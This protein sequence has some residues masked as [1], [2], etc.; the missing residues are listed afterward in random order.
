[1]ARTS[2]VHKKQPERA[3]VTK[4][5]I[6]KIYHVALY[7]R[8]SLLDSGHKDSD[9][10][11][12]QELLLRKFI[13]GKT[14]FSL[15]DV[16]VDNGESG[17]S[18]DRDSFK[19]MMEDVR[20]GRVDCI[21]VKDLSRFGRNYIEAGEY[22]EKVFPFLGVR[23]IAVND[24]I[25]TADPT[26]CDGL[27]LHLRN[28]VNDVYARD[29]SKKIS[30]VL[31]GKQQRGEFIGAWAAYGY[32]K[33][34]EDKH[35]L[36]IDEK[37]APVVRDIFA[38]RIEGFSYKD[39][40]RR[41]TAQGIPS[42]SK[43]RYMEGLVHDKRFSDVP[44]R[45]ETVKLI[46]GNEVYLGHTVQ[47]RKREC[48]FQGIKREWLPK[49]QWIIVKNT[50]KAIIDQPIFDKVQKINLIKKQKRKEMKE[51]FPEVGYTENILKG[52]VCCSICGE[53]LARRRNIWE[54]KYKTP[55]I[56]VWYKYICPAHAS[57]PARCS[58]Q[59]IKEQELLQAVFESIRMQV[60]L[61]GN[62]EKIVSLQKRNFAR[63]ERLQINSQLQKE[64]MELEK[65]KRHK[66]SLYDD[67]ADNLM[68]EQDY[69][70]AQARYREKETAL[71][72]H[73]LELNTSLELYNKEEP[74][75]NLWLKNTLRFRDVTELTREM[76]CALIE[77][78]TVYHDMAL[79]ITFR[80]QDDFKKLQERL[81]EG[82]WED[83]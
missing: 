12:T 44:W 17:V 72:R 48:L 70:Y 59:G 21:I 45:V 34:K 56:Q 23:F 10:A 64:R 8:L 80:F 67:Y 69:L 46:M 75:K 51:R 47:G 4:E 76:A 62:M 14:Y 1:M 43:Y 82:K 79:R 66:E 50:H 16:Y 68:N 20:A 36:V 41:L 65:I 73:I 77:K 71:Q 53:R 58:F 40:V 7:V 81:F 63:D 74:Q 61:A 11:E 83:E 28:L 37:T 78:I 35:Q 39:I 9:T 2:R 31:H 42:P 3:E 24:G 22:L 29:I 60:Q 32:R 52:L 57:D 49:G 13:E 6:E 54:N 15:F 27:A 30:T 19:R 33:S 18:F 25:D 55:K 26:S 5:P 38:W